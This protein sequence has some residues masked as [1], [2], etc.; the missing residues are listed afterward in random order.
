MY[1]SHPSPSLPARRIAESERPPTRSGGPPSRTGAGSIE[2]PEKLIEA[3]VEGSSSLGQKRPKSDNDPRRRDAPRSLDRH[4]SCLEIASALAAD[5][6]PEKQP[7]AREVI[8]RGR[9]L[10]DQ[11]R[12][13]QREEDDTRA[14]QDPFG[15]R[16]E[17]R[18]RD[19]EIE[20]RVVEREVLACPDRVVPELLRELGDGTEAAGVGKTLRELPRSLDP[21]LDQPP[22]RR[23]CRQ[24]F[25]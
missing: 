4:P 14:E 15:H 16:G 12:V 2:T 3:A 19:A 13:P 1:G 8:E 11:A 23:A 24:A 5:A 7:S 22:G 10:R 25:S 18:E 20:D 21:D 6:E 9:L 17:R